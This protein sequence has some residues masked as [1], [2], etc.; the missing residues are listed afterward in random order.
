MKGGVIMDMIRAG[1]QKLYVELPE[2]TGRNVPIKEIAEA[3]L[4]V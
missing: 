2:F 1:E 4:G 3:M